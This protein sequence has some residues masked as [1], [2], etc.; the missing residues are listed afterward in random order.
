MVRDIAWAPY[1]GGQQ[2]LLECPLFECLITGNRGGGKR[3]AAST[4]VATGRGWVRADAVRIDDY[5]IAP[6][7][8]YTQVLGIYPGNSSHFYRFRFEDGAE[9]DACADHRWAVRDQK[10]GWVVKTTADLAKSRRPWSIP[11]ISAPIPGRQWD[12]PDPYV[13]GLVLGDGT[14]GS[15]NVTVYSVDEEII[16][17]LESRHGWKRY[18]DHATRVVC[19]GDQS[20]WRDLLPRQKIPSQ[21]LDADPIARLEL[22]RGLMD[23]DGSVDLDGRC[24]FGSISR[25]LADGVQYLTRSLGGRASVRWVDKISPLGGVG[26]WRVCLSPRGQFNPFRLTRKAQRVKTNHY[27]SETRSIKSITQVEGGDGVCFA[28]DHPSRCFVIEGCV[29]THNTDV[30]VM[31]FAREVGRG[32]GAEWRGILF[33]QTFP[34]LADVVTK[35][36]KW[37]PRIFPSAGFNEQKHVW[38]FADGETLRLSYIERESD[39]WNYH[40]HEY[41]W[42]GFEELTTWPDDKCYKIMMSCS[43]SSYPGIPKRYRATTNPYGRGHNWV[44]ARFSLPIPPGEI[45]AVTGTPPRAAVRVMLADNLALAKA[46]PGYMQKVLAA[47]P[48]QSARRAWELEDWDV[49]SGGM[50]DDVWSP[51]SSIIGDFTIAD[52]LQTRWRLDRSYDHGQSAP[53]SVGWWAESNGE[54]IKIGDR[55]VGQVP[56]DIIRFAEL[57]GWRGQPNEGLRMSAAEIADGIHSKEREWGIAGRVLPGPADSSIFDDFE[58]GRSVAGEMARR[59][60]TWIPADKGPGSRKQGWQVLRGYMAGA[61][62]GKEGARENPGIFV[63]RRCD[64]F[65]RT[66]PCLPRSD[67]DLDDVDTKAEDHVAD[68]TRY[69]LRKKVRKAESRDF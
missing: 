45:V 34:Q 63:C 8:T 48:N 61:V 55:L 30:L 10:T 64:Q 7:G 31:D 3:V 35:T 51:A 50:F 41:P 57:Y 47:A 2:A 39:Y 46:D 36:K 14:L 17:Y 26:Y 54:P 49:T 18:R 1:F 32:Y 19:L 56:G 21:L 69:R 44:R 22:L 43:R 33:R 13:A 15:K 53:F 68:E 27:R 52:L 24:E 38:T 16:T 4:L 37:F 25:H 5:L 9:I 28:V 29:V 65:V 42:I 11:Y 40:G 60:V 59:G 12:G 23:S 20:Q 6:D 66:V 62:P 58:P 67:N